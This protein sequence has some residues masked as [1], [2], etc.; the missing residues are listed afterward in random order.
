MNEKI[1]KIMEHAGVVS[2]VTGIVMAAA[3]ISSSVLLIVY[4][5]KLLKTKKHV[6][7]HI[8]TFTH[9]LSVFFRG[10]WKGSS[11]ENL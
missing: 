5:A 2:I 4:G 1:Y 11:R 7:C 6:V 9:I 10:A 8:R 3:A